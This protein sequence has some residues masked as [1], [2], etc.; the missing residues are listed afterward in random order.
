MHPVLEDFSRG[1]RLLLD[2]A[3]GSELERRGVLMPLPLWSAAALETHPD[4]V[5]WVHAEYA[6]AG[7]RVLTANTFR[8][9]A[10]TA[11]QTGRGANWAKTLT[12]RAVDLARRAAAQTLGAPPIAVAG[13]MAPLEDCYHPDRAPPRDVAEEEHA[14]QAQILADAGADLLLIETMNTVGEAR[15]ALAGARRACQLPVWVSLIPGPGLTLLDGTALP[16]ALET[17]AADGPDALLLNCLP[18]DYATE[19]LPLFSRLTIPWGFYANASRLPGAIFNLW[20]D[21]P[22]AN[23]ARHGALWLSAGAQIV[24]GCCGTTPA[25]MAALAPRFSLES[26]SKGDINIR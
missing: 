23:Y 13:A 1:G 11:V 18:A 19:C 6:A 22:P 12:R 16:K 21:I 24:G 8:T 5:G 4:V 14:A 7:C 20:D 3:M 9:T 2:G 26:P 17:V 10:R 15:A 25:H